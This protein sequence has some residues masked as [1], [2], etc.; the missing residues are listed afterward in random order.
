M[1]NHAQFS[2]GAIYNIYGEFSLNDSEFTNNTARDGG[3]L[4][5]DN[6]DKCTIIN[7][8]FSYNGALISGG[9]AYI[10]LCNLTESLNSFSHNHALLDADIH[11]SDSLDLTIGS[12]N[13]TMYK[14]NSTQ[15]DVLPSY[16]SLIDEKLVTPVKDQQ[17]S[18]NC[19]A[20]APIAVME[21]CI[22]KA[23]GDALDL[24]EEN[25]KNHFKGIR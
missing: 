20:F 14:V 22:L 2:G 11:I 10:F 5:I 13:Y 9:A 18:G 1:I 15:I 25:M 23:S 21:S 8:A 3:A 6:S 16:Y 19:W 24:S 17:T 12:G 7:N 4:F